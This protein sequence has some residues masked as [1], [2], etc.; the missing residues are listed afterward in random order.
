[1]S[2]PNLLRLD[3]INFVPW[4]YSLRDYLHEKEKLYV[5]VRP[6]PDLPPQEDKDATRQWWKHLND[7]TNVSV[8]IRGTIDIPL[9]QG[10]E[11][12]LAYEMIQEM[13]A[14]F[15]Q[16]LNDER[17]RLIGKMRHLKGCEDVTS[18]F[19]ALDKLLVD[20]ELLGFT[21]PHKFI[22]GYVLK[23]LG[24][25]F[26]EVLENAKV[27]LESLSL[28]EMHY[29]LKDLEDHVPGLRVE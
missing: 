29:M 11:I 28:N 9:Y 16:H 10:L 8:L 1:M 22:V 19:H 20:F 21:I 6:L 7:S 25:S 24:R 3:D 12:P 15:S 4:L 23:A 2:P 13:K 26:N 18:I 14:R 27:D 17:K 5:I